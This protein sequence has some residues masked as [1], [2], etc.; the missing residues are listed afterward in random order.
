MK[1][2][3]ILTGC[4]FII[5]FKA[6]AQDFKPITIGASL[7]Y[8]YFNSDPNSTSSSQHITNLPSLGMFLEYRFQ[9]VFSL[10]M[11]VTYAKN[12]W[13]EP[14]PITGG[15][16]TYS[17]LRILPTLNFHLINARTGK[18]EHE[19]LAST[20]I[21]Y[22]QISLTNTSDETAIPSTVEYYFPVSF[23]LSLGYG[24]TAFDRWYSKL[25]FSLGGAF[26]T[27]GTGVRF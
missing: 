1:N 8:N 5:S 20:G 24:I 13:F 26:V 23:K 22:R 9:K 18:V 19:L 17:R 2:L 7:G 21:G 3:I 12:E 15:T 6:K 14:N 16:T 25:E 4:L 27:F 10:G 11:D